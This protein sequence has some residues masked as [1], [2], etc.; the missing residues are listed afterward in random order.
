MKWF[1]THCTATTFNI[2]Y[3]FAISTLVYSLYLLTS[4][5][6]EGVGVAYQTT[7]DASI[8]VL[9]TKDNA[10][11]SMKT[12]GKR[13]RSTINDV[14]FKYV[15]QDPLGA[16]TFARTIIKGAPS[17]PYIDAYLKMPMTI[18]NLETFLDDKHLS[19]ITDPHAG[20]VYSK[21]A[22]K[23]DELVKSGELQGKRRMAMMAYRDYI[24][25]IL[26]QAYGIP[27]AP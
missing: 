24:V 10:L 6:Y 22:I 7:K 13:T 2:I 17:D 21:I 8:A 1:A 11:A 9:K 26:R 14:A 23:L 18:D 12:L 4:K 27:G 25:D 15:Q 20:I 5:L 16:N 19:N 3:I